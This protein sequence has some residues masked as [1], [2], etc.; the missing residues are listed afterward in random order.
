MLFYLGKYYAQLHAIE[1]IEWRDC[2]GWYIVLTP[3]GHESY[4]N[5]KY[6]ELV[7]PD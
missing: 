7:C 3:S 4:C 1:L 6:F 2:R 5:P